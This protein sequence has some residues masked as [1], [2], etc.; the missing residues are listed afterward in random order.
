MV[1]RPLLAVDQARA[2]SPPLNAV[3]S[4]ESRNY[5]FSMSCEGGACTLTLEPDCS[6]TRSG[7]AGRACFPRVT[8]GDASGRIRPDDLVLHL[9]ELRV[10]KT[11]ETTDGLVAT[12]L[13]GEGTF[14]DWVYGGWTKAQL[15]TS[16]TPSSLR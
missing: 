1:R 16:P 4:K 11:I 10:T 15:E 14:V 6:W 13:E 5:E 2:D 7:S 12:N 3:G 9:H 8:W